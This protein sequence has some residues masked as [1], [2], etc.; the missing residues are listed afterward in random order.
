MRS[1]TSSL[2][3]YTA[4]SS[5]ACAAGY[6]YIGGAPFVL[7]SGE[8]AS[9]GQTTRGAHRQW[10]ATHT[11]RARSIA[12]VP[13]RIVRRL[14][15]PRPS[16]T[17]TDLLLLGLLL[18]NVVRVVAVER[19]FKDEQRHRDLHEQDQRTEIPARAE[20]AHVPSDADETGRERRCSSPAV[21]PGG[22]AVHLTGK[23]EQEEEGRN[24]GARRDDAREARDLGV[25]HFPVV[26]HLVH[27]A[28]WDVSYS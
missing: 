10:H 21:C 9:V 12:R 15:A 27:Q 7:L 26:Q 24:S 3:T 25:F 13:C 6:K 17:R 14:E 11:G 8:A 5:S 19:R 2:T 4:A 18:V 23:A 28:E 1:S 16:R 22:A 20:R